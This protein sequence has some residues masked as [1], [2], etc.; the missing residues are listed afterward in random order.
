MGQIPFANGVECFT[1]QMPVSV[2]QLGGV[3]AS[4]LRNPKEH[5]CALQTALFEYG[6]AART[7]SNFRIGDDTG[8][9][10][11]FGLD[12]PETMIVKNGQQSDKQAHSF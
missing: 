12:V 7:S 2:C 4:R 3:A 9:K 10:L 8:T 5:F 1:A 6:E 11:L